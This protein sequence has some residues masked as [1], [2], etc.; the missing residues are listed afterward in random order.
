MIFKGVFRACIERTN[1]V[2]VGGALFELRR[3]SPYHS[4]HVEQ[5][6]ANVVGS[7]DV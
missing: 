5:R 1:M 7:L 4:L 3:L 6:I 2:E